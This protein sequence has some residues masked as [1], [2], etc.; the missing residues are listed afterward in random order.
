MKVGFVITNHNSDISPDG[1]SDTHEF[2]ESIKSSVQ[3]EYEIILMDNQSVPRYTDKYTTDGL[4]YIDIEDQTLTG[5]TG[6]WNV[7]IKKAYDLGCEIINNCNNDLIFS[8]SINS[9]LKLI[10]V[11]PRKDIFLFGPAT[12]PGGAPGHFQETVRSEENTVTEVTSKLIGLNGFMTS[13]CKEFFEEHRMG[14]N[15]YSPAKEYLWDAQEHEIRKR[16]SEKGLREFVIHNTIV[17]H[18]KHRNWIKMK[19]RITGIEKPYWNK[20]WS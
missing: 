13:F 2:I 3:C 4:T 6:A 11:C 16:L 1:N 20:E 8:E 9:Y 18:K 12:N 10:N 5:I 19:K 15:L 14:D 17:F 7:G